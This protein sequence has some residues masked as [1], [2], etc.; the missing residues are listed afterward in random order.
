MTLIDRD[1]ALATLKP[2]LPDLRACITR[3]WEQYH[4]QP[5]AQEGRASRR[6]RASLVHDLIV[7]GARRLFA[8]RPGVRID[9]GRGFLVLVFGERVAVRFKK[10][11][12][13]MRPSHIPTE[14]AQSFVH[15]L[16]LFGEDAT[17]LIAGYQLDE[18]GVTLEHIAITCPRGDGVAWYAMID[19]PTMAMPALAVEAAMPKPKIIVKKSA[20]DDTGT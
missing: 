8:G 4:I 6:S 10:L 2:F 1:E 16:S 15:Q 19:A 3:G 18:L 12:G 13:A 5:V 11:N 20:L 7:D 17:N 9:E 14:Q